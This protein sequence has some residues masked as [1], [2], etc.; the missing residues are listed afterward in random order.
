MNA[1]KGFTL[2]ELLVVFAIMALLVSVVPFSFERMRQSAQ[3]RDALRGMI[4]DLRSARQQARQQGREIV[5]LVDL[6]NR[7][8]GVWGG[9]QKSVPEP[10]QM[11]ATVAGREMS[12]T[13][14]AGIRF[15][16]EG[17]STGGSIDLFQASGAGTRVRVDWFSGQVSQEPINP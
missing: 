4:S 6:P 8:F 7:R 14:V 5:F 16:P 9:A 17:G 3:Y 10:L 13:Q 11:R 12:G 15:L 1:Q 2:I